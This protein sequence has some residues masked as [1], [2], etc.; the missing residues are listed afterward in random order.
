MNPFF[1]ALALFLL[2]PGC[3]VKTQQMQPLT[4]EFAEPA[5]EE[6]V[7]TCAA[8]Y[9]AGNW[10][11]VHS[12]EFT[13]ADGSGSSLLGVTVLGA[14]A[15]SCALMTTEG[16]TLFEAQLA[17]TLHILRAV[18][19]FDKPEFAQALMNDVQAIFVPPRGE[20]RQ[21]GT[22]DD[23]TDCCRTTTADSRLTTDVLFT[24]DNCWQ[25]NTFDEQRQMIRSITARS[26]RVVGTTVI[27]E[28]L[29]LTVP[30]PAGYTLKMTL[31]EAVPGQGK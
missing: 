4:S 13:T 25:I 31:V 20:K 29:E 6:A 27:P 26:C 5:R 3:A 16:F 7:R 19:P 8:V 10:Q 11:L 24:E 9:P 22:L 30:G 15:L 21:Y 2:L 12:I 18:P 14:D 17:D 23:R 1:A 28:K